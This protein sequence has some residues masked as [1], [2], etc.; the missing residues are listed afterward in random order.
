[1]QRVPGLR[2]G[3]TFV[4]PAP[5]V[6]VLE[7]DVEGAVGRTAALVEAALVPTAGRR[8]R[9]HRRRPH[10]AGARQYTMSVKMPSS[11]TSEFAE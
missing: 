10:L 9:R 11:V 6:E 3:R 1:V 2:V 4:L 7:A 8:P 5:G